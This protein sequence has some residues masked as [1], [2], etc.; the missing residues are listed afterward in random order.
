M[1]SITTYAI[2]VGSFSATYAP[3]RLRE[4][5]NKASMTTQV[6]FH[7]VIG[8][9]RGHE[10]NHN[11]LLHELLKLKETIRKTIVFH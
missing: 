5:F 8:E 1:I 4:I 3:Q 9:V 6:G 7:T 10:W 2:N 11:I